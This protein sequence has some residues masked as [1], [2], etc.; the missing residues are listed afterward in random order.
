VRASRPPAR[1]A[2]SL[3]LGAGRAG[4]AGRPGVVRQGGPPPCPALFLL[5]FFLM[6]CFVKIWDVY[7][8]NICVEIDVCDEMRML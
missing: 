2:R 1:G 6:L 4:G 3:R 8:L 7:K 5:F